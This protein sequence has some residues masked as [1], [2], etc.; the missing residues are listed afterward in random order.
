MG[1]LHIAYQIVIDKSGSMTGNKLP[2]VKTAAKM[3]VDLAPVGYSTIGV[4]AYNDTVT[5][6]QPLTAITTAR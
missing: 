3:L 5:V 4:I 6:V 1:Q 2:N